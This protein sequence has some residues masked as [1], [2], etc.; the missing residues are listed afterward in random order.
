M[1][2]SLGTAQFGSNYG[3][4]NHEGQISVREAK[5][6]LKIAQSA[7]IKTLDTAVSYGL[8]EEVLGEIGVNDFHC[9]SKLPLLPKN[10]G[11]IKAWVNMQIIESINRL[12][13]PYL[14]G[15]L[16]HHPG[17]ILGP[18]GDEYLIALLDAKDHGYIKKIGFSIYSPEILAKV[19]RL[20]WPDIVQV[21]YNVFDQ[22]I[23]TSGWLD[24]LVD[25]GTKIH[26]RSIFLQ[27]LLLMQK[28]KRPTYFDKWNK[29][30]AKWDE[31]VISQNTNSMECALNYV[32]ANNKIDKV[33]VGVDTGKQLS[34]LI[35][36]CKSELRSELSSL[37][38]DDLNLIEPSRWRLL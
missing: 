32:I 2:L 38:I 19:T 13:L 26:A 33:I 20:F 29:D 17:D 4:A 5:S 34:E 23:N 15:M 30:L 6:I 14:Y 12:G 1:K 22:R 16:L 36:A 3:V 18:G 24:R 35:S 27:G 8:A 10:V 25:R 31:M 7:G 28:D 9:I 37:E 11:D 21:P